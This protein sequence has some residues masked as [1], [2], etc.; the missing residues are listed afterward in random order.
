MSFDSGALCESGD[1]ISAC[2]QIRF[3]LPRSATDADASGTEVISPE[4]KAY[5]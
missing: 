5:P 4:T 1:V 3:I 2:A